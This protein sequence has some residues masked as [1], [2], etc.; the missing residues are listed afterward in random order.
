MVRKWGPGVPRDSLL[1]PGVYVQV[2]G[3]RLLYG[4]YILGP[5]KVNSN[6]PLSPTDGR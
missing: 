5:P 6:R 1:G 2:Q 4:I 3:L